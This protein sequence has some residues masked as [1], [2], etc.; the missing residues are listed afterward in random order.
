MAA[1]VAMVDKIQKEQL[2]RRVLSKPDKL[3]SDNFR[4]RLRLPR[5]NASG[6]T[7]HIWYPNSNLSVLEDV[8]PS[9]EIA[10]GSEHEPG[11]RAPEVEGLLYAAYDRAA[12][13][14]ADLLIGEEVLVRKIVEFNR[15]PTPSKR[16]LVA[17]PFEHLTGRMKSLARMVSLPSVHGAGDLW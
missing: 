2:G 5:I 3:I 6:L 1:S 16:V 4:R 17:T 15:G 11:S 10:L 7:G 12:A 8:K 9:P 13:A 14:I